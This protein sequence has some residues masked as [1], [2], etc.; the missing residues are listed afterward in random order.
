VGG[1]ALSE[2]FTDQKIAR[3]Y[4]HFV[5][6]AN[7]SMS[8]LELAKKIQDPKRFAELKRQVAERQKNSAPSAYVEVA[9]PSVSTTRSSKIEFLAEVPRPPDFDRH[10]LTNT[11]IEQ[12]W[13]F[14]NPLMLYVRHLGMKGKVVKLLAAGDYQAAEAEEGGAKAREIWDAVH[15]LK[16]ETKSLFKPKAVYQYLRAAAEGNTI[17]LFDP[18]GKK[19]ESM[20]FPRQVGADGL[21]LAD[22][23]RSEAQGGDNLGM[24]VVGVGEGVRETAERWKQQGEYL[25]S[26]AFQALALES[27]EGYAELLHSRLRS[28]WG[29][30][31]PLEQSMLERFQAKYRGKRYSFGYPACP[32]LDEQQVIWRL[33]KPEEIGIELT[34]GMMMDPEASVSAIVFHHPQAEYFNVG[35]A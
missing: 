14:I 4:E 7:D 10:V 24:F 5:T 16:A 26:H 15:D 27:A 33:L 31:D 9:V 22:Y 32:S 29:F 35:A 18:A 13:E 23:L 19:L 25:K 28:G 30:P 2:K 12:I 8:G 11:P 21:S 6:Y 20:T 17:H 34:S 1:A 3:A